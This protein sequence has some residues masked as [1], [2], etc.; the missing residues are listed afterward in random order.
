MSSLWEDEYGLLNPEFRKRSENGI[1]VTAEYYIL[2]NKP[3]VPAFYAATRL[4]VPGHPGLYRQT[5][6]DAPADH[7]EPGLEPTSHDN[8]T[9]IVT[10]MK[11]AGHE[12]EVEAVWSYLVRNLFTY[13][14]RTP[15]KIS[16]K[17]I[18]HPRDI[19]YYGYLA[20]NFICW[21]L[22]PILLVMQAITCARPKEETSG[23]LLCW[24][25]I[26]CLPSI[27][28]KL[29]Y[30]QINKQYVGGLKELFRI[31]YP[32]EGHPTNVTLNHKQGERK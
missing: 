25:R 24:M 31:Y 29:F 1:K 7:G 26:Q 6:W 15:G 9:A 32:N 3:A 22:L 21:L 23:K 28:S 16:L 5:P 17:R 4:S 13:D 27:F 8:L 2:N 19:I 14:F 11:L 12:V 30:Y 20:N 10:S 18:M